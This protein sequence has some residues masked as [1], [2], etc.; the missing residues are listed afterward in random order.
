[1]GNAAILRG[2]ELHRQAFT[3]Q[4][5]GLIPSNITTTGARLTWDAATP[6]AGDVL[7]S[8][9]VYRN[10]SADRTITGQTFTIYNNMAPGTAYTYTVSAMARDAGEGPQS[11]A[12]VV[13][14]DAAS[15]ATFSSAAIYGGGFQNVL[16]V[17][18]FLNGSGKRPILAGHDNAGLFWSVDQTNTWKPAYAQPGQAVGAVLWH[19]TTSGTCYALC[20]DGFYRSTDY[21]LHWT[22]RAASGSASR[23]S[24]D[25]N[26]KYRSSA[27]EHPR[28]TGNMI[29]QDNSTAT[30]YLWVATGTAISGAAPTSIRRSIDDGATWPVEALTGNNYRSIASDPNN[31]SN[32]FVA[33]FND[34]N[35]NGGAAGAAAADTG[36]WLLPAA[37]GASSMGTPQNLAYPGSQPEEIICI[38][39]AG[40][41]LLFVAGKAGVYRW[42]GTAWANRSTGLDATVTYESIHGYRKTDGTIVLFVGA[43]TNAAGADSK[44]LRRQIFRSLD[45]GS[46][47]TQITNGTASVIHTAMYGSTD[48]W[49]LNYNSYN[50]FATSQYVA[51]SLETNPD[52]RSVLYCAGRSGCWTG[53]IG[54]SVTDW[55]PAMRGLMSTACA[56][57]ATDPLNPNRFVVANVDYKSI[58]SLDGG[59][60]AVSSKATGAGSAG[61]MVSWDA[62][63]GKCYI[64]TADRFDRRTISSPVGQA[65]L[66]SNANVN[67]TTNW[68]DEGLTGSAP[69][70]LTVAATL[71]IPVHTVFRNSTNQ[72][73]LLAATQHVGSASKFWRK[74]GTGSWTQVTGGPFVALSVDG[75]YGKIMPIAGTDTVYA[76]DSKALWRSKD[77]GATWTKLYAATDALQNH[78]GP[79]DTL[80]I[81]TVDNTIVYLSVNGNLLR[82]DNAFSATGVADT[83]TTTLLGA[84]TT[85]GPIAA[86]FGKLLAQDQLNGVRLLLYASP[87]TATAATT[88]T[89]L[90][91]DFFRAQGPTIRALDVSTDKRLRTAEK[92]SGVMVADLSSV[93]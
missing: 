78:D 33:V 21:G 61:D 27:D 64:S 72:V 62:A 55:Y 46:T 6:P 25:A 57:V 87:R 89:D 82:V 76:R 56:H 53:E 88:P 48:S 40:S 5:T 44:G 30:K 37:K 14:T 11:A 43:A 58:L 54:A 60:T 47:W 26:G 73:V 20:D 66:A 74:A 19:D 59:L 2:R 13:T 45:G 4:V 92:G 65:V 51:A 50:K 34:P 1:M 42:N 49:W 85:I 93:L 38:D 23:I 8:Y 7:V 83:A 17:S 24:A 86:A 22:K 80:A 52:N 41:T 18:P 16:A 91:D 69:A 32:L 63:N 31:R 68:I 77:S 10:G 15:T 67:G 70:P 39:N 84:G 90:A 29:A 3:A 71:G 28:P 81:D 9:L 75:C 35:R 12:V 36:V 79:V